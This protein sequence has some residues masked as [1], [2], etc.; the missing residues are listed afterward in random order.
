MP[1]IKHLVECHCKLVIFKNIDHDIYHKFPVYSKINEYGKIIEKFRKCNNCDALHKIYDIGKSEIFPG[2]DQ[3][4]TI[5]KIEDFKYSLDSIIF[6]FL[7]DNNSDISN[8]YH[9]K[10]IIEE[11][12]WGEN[13]VI[14]RDIIDEKTQ[15][16]YITIESKNN[17]K[18]KNNILEDTIIYEE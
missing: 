11:K 4:E 12:R 7:K 1:G 8:Y 10:D 6:N 18:I 5:M 9:I 16:K 2:K 14:K 3:S 15:V 13:V 17:F